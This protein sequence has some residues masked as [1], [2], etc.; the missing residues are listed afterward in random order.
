MIKPAKES[1]RPVTSKLT[2]QLTSKK[3]VI[4]CK[5]RAIIRINKL[6]MHRWFQN[7]RY[8]MENR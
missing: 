2:S 3:L 4:A 1:H 5:M 8:D 6:F 7:R